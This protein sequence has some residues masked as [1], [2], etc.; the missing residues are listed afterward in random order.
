MTFFSS[1]VHGALSD[2]LLFSDSNLFTTKQK[3]LRASCGFTDNQ[4]SLHEVKHGF[5]LPFSQP[6]SAQPIL[7]IFGI[8]VEEVSHVHKLSG[9]SN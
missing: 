9:I 4:F 6:N 3:L 1:L 7:S 8:A 2:K 5:E